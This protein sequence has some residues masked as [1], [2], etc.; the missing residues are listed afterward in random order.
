VDT[1]RQARALLEMA[2]H[3]VLYSPRMTW[4]ELDADDALL[5]I[6]GS[7]SDAANVVQHLAWRHR[8]TEGG[9][10]TCGA[11]WRAGL[12]AIESPPAFLQN[13]SYNAEQTRRAIA[14]LL[15]RGG[16]VGSVVGGLVNAQDMQLQ[17]PSSGMSVKVSPGEAW[18][19]G[20]SAAT[21]SGYYA[22]VSSTTTLA[23]AASDPSNPR[24]DRI[25]AVVADAAYS[26]GR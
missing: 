11:D 20:S 18:I 25:S 26:G 21:Q 5:S 16:S 6:E 7:H 4:L 2:G 3:A 14:N 10:A 17:P 22:R 19:A 23:I 8:G 15:Q 9:S 13:S 12:M 24:I 1:A